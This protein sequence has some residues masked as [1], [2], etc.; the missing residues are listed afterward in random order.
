VNSKQW[1]T[2][3]QHNDERQN[4]MATVTKKQKKGSA[5]SI[6]HNANLPLA[7]AL[8][9]DA[10]GETVTD[11]VPIFQPESEDGLHVSEEVYWADYYEHPEFK[12]EWNNGILEEK[13]MSN[14]E[15]SLL[16]AWF[17]KLLD[18]F[19]IHHPIAQ[20][21]GLE[22]GGYVP[23]TDETVI[24]RPDLWVI[25]NSNPTS[26]NVKN[27]TYQGTFDMCIEAISKTKEKYKIKD[28]ITK[29]REYALGGIKEYY[30]LDGDGEETIF[31]RLNNQ[32]MYEEIE[33][34]DGVTC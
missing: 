30:I 9:P 22:I 8:S 13:G 10:N 21:V 3:K 11:E 27:N 32:D 28:T 12:Y 1:A 7:V 25:L 6:T 33:N 14:I 16:Y 19:L 29:K 24:R 34:K 17:W 15:T 23:I 2:N 26:L 31:Y 18:E 5:L 20:A 4:I